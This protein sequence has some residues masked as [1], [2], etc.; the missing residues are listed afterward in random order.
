MPGIYYLNGNLHSA[1]SNT[2]RNAWIGGQPSTQGVM[3]YFL[4]GGPLFAGCSGCASANVDNVPSYYLNCS[5]TSAPTGVPASMSGNVLLSQCLV[6]GTYY[7]PPSSDALSSSGSRGLLFFT[8]PS[9]VFTGTV[10]GASGT[11]VFSG[12]FYFHSTGYLDQPNFNGAG[13]STTVFLGR[14]VSDQLVLSGSGTITMELN[15]N[16]SIGVLKVALFQ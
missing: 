11:L 7:G 8:D 6:N 4:T 13:A 5:G 10:F 9:D 14:I 3:F 12:S 1:S 16:P 2:L 15:P